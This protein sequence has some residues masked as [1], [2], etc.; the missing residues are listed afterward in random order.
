MWTATT[1]QILA[2][3]Y[4]V[5]LILTWLARHSARWRRVWHLVCH[6]A[7]PWGPAARWAVLLL[8]APVLLVTM[9]VVAASWQR[10]VAALM[11]MQQT[12]TSG[13]LR[14]GLLLVV[15]GVGLL[16]AARGI[17]W[18]ARFLARAL[19]RW[20]RLPWRLARAIGAVL[21]GL[22]VVTVVNDV[23]LRRALSVADSTFSGIN[24]G[25]YP[26]VEQPQQPTRSG[27]PASLVPWET[28]GREGRSFVAGGRSPQELAEAGAR[29]PL[30]P[31]RVYVGLQSA[32]TVQQRADLAVGELERTG[33][34]G[35]SVLAIVTTT[36]TGWV[37]APAPESL[38]LLHGGDTAIVATQY[39]YLPSWLSSSSTAPAPSRPAGCSSTPSTPAWTSCRSV[40]FAMSSPISCGTTTRSRPLT[41]HTG[42]PSASERT[43]ARMLS[44]ITASSGRSTIGVSA[45]S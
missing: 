6:R 14:A 15:V 11:S 7:P 22:L 1:E 33:A 42:Q 39:S 25:T 36:G 8:A 32:L 19:G 38:E 17:R 30:D 24:S 23:L 35:R 4:G 16:A 10:E 41:T 3:V 28:L 44:D 9:L 12:T 26:R 20:A 43:V 45:P 21:A 27:S 40:T 34:F 31:I 18:L 13:W 29:P 2:K 5:G 37:N